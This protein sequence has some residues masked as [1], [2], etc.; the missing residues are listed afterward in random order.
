MAAIRGKPRTPPY[1]PI[2]TCWKAE[3]KNFEEKSGNDSQ[4]GNHLFQTG[5]TAR[6][7]TIV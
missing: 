7:A 3:G 4:N 5:V 2:E 1:L 6:M